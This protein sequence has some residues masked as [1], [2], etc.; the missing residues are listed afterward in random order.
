MAAVGGS[1]ERSSRKSSQED[2]SE[3]LTLSTSGPVIPAK[4]SVSFL[5]R[6]KSEP[7]FNSRKDISGSTSLLLFTLA[8]VVLGLVVGVVLTNLN[9]SD[10]A[11]EVVGFPGELLLRTLKMLVLP[12]IAT[13]II[14]GITSLSEGTGSVSAE[15]RKI[16]LHT[17]LYFGCTT[18]FAVILGIICAE[19]IQVT[20]TSIHAL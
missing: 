11:I 14:V 13:S 19:A 5:W 15:T 16:L 9:V 2:T 12:L 1:E 8:S 10:T 18:V 20:N 3:T 7:L 4:A 6:L 17:L